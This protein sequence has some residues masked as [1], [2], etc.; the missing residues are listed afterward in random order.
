MVYRKG[1]D[2]LI[3]KVKSAREA[4]G[5]SI[6]EAA[7]LL[8]FNN[9]QALSSIER[10]DRKV[11]AHE[12]S[13]MATIY[14][15]DLSYFFDS[16][17]SNDPKPLWRK[18]TEDEHDLKITRKFL[19]FLEN[20]RNLEQLL[21]LKRRWKDVQCTYDKSDFRSRGF[22]L[23]DSLAEKTCDALNL[24]SHPASALRN[25]LENDLRIK[26]LHL[27][28]NHGI[29]GATVVD[30]NLGVG[31]LINVN[32]APWRRNFDLAHELFH[33]ITWNVFTHAE[34]G[35]GLKKTKPEQYANAFAASLLLPGKYLL[36]SVDE[37]TQGGEI[38]LSDLIELAK[39]YGVSTE[40]ILW[41]LVSLKRLKRSQVNN[42]LQNPGVREVDKGMRQE[43]Y[44]E[45]SPSTFPEKYIF[46]ALKCFSEGR[47]SRGTFAKYLDIGREEIDEYLDAHGLQE[48]I[49]EKVAFA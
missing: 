38:M 29:S 34:V 31:I 20:Y 11:K 40:T 22:D 17:A 48:V 24:G 49:Y 9:Y 6:K 10:G 41:R 21:G 33:V 37:I 18:N 15:R 30:E 25:V 47:I 16:D 28:L 2:L 23:V 44:S 3:Q 36:A 27:D 19:V 26:I 7:E 13:A 43:L 46:L 12:L 39:E 32:D 5:F 35:T 42:A 45:A 1:K 14:G 4:A 8:E